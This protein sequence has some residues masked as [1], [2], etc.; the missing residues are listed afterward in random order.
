[1]IIKSFELNKI[2]INTANLILFY[3]K[4][5]G[6]KNQYLKS[7]KKQNKEI[8]NYE[9]KEILENSDNFFNKVLTKS[10]FENERVV[11]I[12]RA[13]EKLLK[14]IENLT[15]NQ[16]EDTII[17]LNADILDKKSKLRSFF[18]KSK[19]FICV[20]FYP[21][22]EQ[23]LSKIA[24]NFLREKNIS[25]SQSNINLIISRSNG[26][27]ATLFNEL[28]KIELYCKGGKKISTEYL[29]KLTNLIENHSISELV[30]NC[31]AKE[32]KKISN[33]LNENNFS[34]EDCILIIRTFLNKSK[35]ILILSNDFNKNKNIE[36][37]ISAAKPPIFWKDKEITRKQIM[38]WKP[39]NL[40]KLIYKLNDIELQIKKNLSNSL[41]VVT[42][43]I[44]EIPLTDPNN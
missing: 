2:K 30:D 21:D 7:L 22:N 20:P 14:I 11:I 6:E 12:K 5:E 33:I 36:K 17:I 1:M 25:I 15:L 38:L 26:D 44:L 8:Y 42:D 37:T 19:E 40:K 24:S 41:Q 3:G 18:E 35:K 13:S 9:E 43:F 27:R 29:L 39:E 28:K 16:L 23:T 4:N 34:N 10:L 32:P 31:L